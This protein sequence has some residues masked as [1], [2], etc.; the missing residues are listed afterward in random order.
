MLLPKFQFFPWDLSKHW[1]EVVV[2]SIP[3]IGIH[4]VSEWIWIKILLPSKRLLQHERGP[5][6]GAKNHVWKSSKTGRNNKIFQKCFG[7]AMQPIFLTTKLGGSVNKNWSFREKNH[8]LFSGQVK[9]MSLSRCAKNGP[10][11]Q[12]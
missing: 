3:T 6:R 9:K 12:F 11:I 7:I 4:R 5:H 10:E 1:S 2:C 8:F